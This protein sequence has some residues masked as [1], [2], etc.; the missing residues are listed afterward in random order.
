[1]YEIGCQLLLNSR[2]RAFDWYQ[3]WWPW[4][5]LNGVIAR[6]YFAFFFTDFDSFAGQLCHSGWVEDRP[7]MSLTYCLP[8]PV[9]HFRPKLT[10]PAARSL[11]DSW[12]SCKFHKKSYLVYRHYSGGVEKVCM[13]LQQSYSGNYVSNFVRIAWVID[14]T[15]TFWSLF[16]THC[17]CSISRSR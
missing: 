3:P 8:V 14:I 12:A 16:R 17:T 15:K 13:I 10:H 1:M 4:M 6:S 5:T 7:I 11:C 9:F 2:I